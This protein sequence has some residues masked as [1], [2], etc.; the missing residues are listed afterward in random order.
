MSLRVTL[1]EMS[2][3]ILFT[4]LVIF[5]SIRP[6]L[7]YSEYVH[8]SIRINFS[9]VFTLLAVFLIFINISFRKKI[10]EFVLLK[11]HVFFLGFA[12]IYIIVSQILQF[13][14]IAN[15]CPD[16]I[17]TYLKTIS[18]TIFSSII[19]FFL[20]FELIRMLENKAKSNLI[21]LSWIVYTIVVF[22]NVGIGANG[23]YSLHLNGEQ[24]YLTLADA[25]ALL[26]FLTLYKINRFYFKVV[27]FF[28]SSV[29]LFLLLSRTSLYLFVVIN[30]IVLFKQSP[31]KFIMLSVVALCWFVSFVNLDVSS[32]ENTR[33]FRF[34][35]TGEDSSW[36]G[37]KL[38]LRDGL[39]HL[40]SYWFL[41]EFMWE[42]KA[43]G[44]KTGNYI[45][46]ILSILNQFGL[47]PFLIIVSSMLI[48][49]IKISFSFIFKNN[50]TNTL[51]FTICSY[52]FLCLIFAR[53]YTV[54]FYWLAL[55]S[56]Y[57]YYNKRK[58]C[59]N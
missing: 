37:R 17:N 48:S 10:D 16:C 7:K 2:S 24:I 51:L 18:R 57:T 21:F 9:I 47:I 30:F 20:G 41:G 40:F 11:P 35:L 12:L 42:V 25:Y 26:S 14:V 23:T 58:L 6:I 49:Y 55:T 13:P 46:N 31:F 59:Q 1:K 28:I 44:G 45:H 5:T 22:A 33:M 29:I 54:V 34:L 19:F 56:T 8:E 39:D 15:S 53:S 32:Y 43:S 52:C 3:L 50:R 36:S 4:F 27:V 38:L